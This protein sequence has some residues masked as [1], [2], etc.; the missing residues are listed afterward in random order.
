MYV[1]NLYQRSLCHC[2][3]H[4]LHKNTDKMLRTVHYLVRTLS[5]HNQ[6]LDMYISFMVSS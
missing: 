4:N 2:A 1:S 6:R 3:L 5:N